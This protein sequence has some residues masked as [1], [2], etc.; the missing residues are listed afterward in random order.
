KIVADLEAVLTREMSGY[1]LVKGELV[2]I[3]NPLEISEVER[4]SK[5]K[6]DYEGIAEHIQTALSL[7]GK[8]PEPDYRNSIKESISAVE[9]AAKLLSGEKSGG[10]DTALAV[11]ERRSALH[12]ALKSALSKLYGYTSDKDGIRHPILEE[13]T[14]TFA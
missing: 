3:T 14:T 8:K 4:A 2:P 10:I 5:P 9:A 13:A 1:R 6:T 11:L 12:P 7:L